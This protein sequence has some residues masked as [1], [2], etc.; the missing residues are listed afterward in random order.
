M[1]FETLGALSV[2]SILISCVVQIAVL[3]KFVAMRDGT[4]ASDLGFDEYRGIIHTVP[5]RL[6]AS[7]LGH[8]KTLS[9]IRARCSRF[10]SPLLEE[11]QRLL[12]KLHHQTVLGYDNS[13]NV[14]FD[15]L[16]LYRWTSSGTGI[17]PLS[18]DQAERCWGSSFAPGSAMKIGDKSKTQTTVDLIEEV[19][20]P[21]SR[22]C[23]PGYFD[24]SILIR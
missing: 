18:R 19:C 4:S 17:V 7:S 20:S 21:T 5:E 12:E 3:W 16:I 24:L 6:A 13:A 2:F 14:S 11:V 22:I 8:L 1:K 10:D 15:V 9:A 23:E